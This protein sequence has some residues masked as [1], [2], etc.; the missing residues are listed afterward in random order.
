MWGLGTS[1]AE[2]VKEAKLYLSDGGNNYAAMKLKGELTISPVTA[3]TAKIIDEKGGA[4]LMLK[5]N[6]DGYGEV[7]YYSQ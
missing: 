1:E 3:E 4:D 6:S 7:H 2:A 5:L